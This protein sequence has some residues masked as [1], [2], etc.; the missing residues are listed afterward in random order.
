MNRSS[1]LAARTASETV[2]EQIRAQIA[3]G[4][5]SPGEMLPSETVLLDEFGVARPTMREALRILESDGLVRILRGVNGGAQV[6]EPELSTLARRA[7]LY[8]QMQN[9]HLGDLMECL[10]IIQPRAVAMAAKEA[11]ST[12]LHE[13][14]TQLGIIASATD[15]QDFTD[16]A[17]E[18]LNLLVQASGNQ[19]LAFVSTLLH[20]LIRVEARALVA[21]HKRD[22]DLRVDE[23][24]RSWCVD[25]YAN[26]LDLI[27]SGEADNAE[28]FWD[29]HLRLVPSTVDDAS[30]LMIYEPHRPRRKAH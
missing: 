1:R 5:I 4:A 2:A 14:R 26:L 22:H 7:G 17:T 27:E 16:E 12:Q 25:Q 19:A 18:F 24:F 20:R 11:T 29:E 10:S 6:R 30:A 15:N 9:V 3:T 8:L 21:E 23:E 13:L 28:A